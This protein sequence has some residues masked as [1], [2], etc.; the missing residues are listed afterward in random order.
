IFDLKGSM[1][2][3]HV[4]STGKQ[5]EVLLDEN[6]VE[7]RQE[8]VVGIVDFIRTFTWDKKLESWVKE[9][10]ILGGGG[11][12]P[13]IVSPRQYRIRFREAMERYFL[14]VPDYWALTRQSQSSYAALHHHQIIQSDSDG[15]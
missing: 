10:G 7:Q 1:R 11:K 15:E 4:Q 13:T 12:G 3:R 8:L 5:D 2:N 9:S 6:L 14:M